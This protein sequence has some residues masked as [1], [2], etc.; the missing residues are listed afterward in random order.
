MI[1]DGS[2]GRSP[3]VREEQ[4]MEARERDKEGA[5]RQQVNNDV[6]G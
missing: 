5:I 6:T 4:V 1:L 3:R 2:E